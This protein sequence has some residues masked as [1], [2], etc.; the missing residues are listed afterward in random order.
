M[1]ELTT[2]SIPQWTYSHV[3]DRR[4]QTLLTRPRICHTYLTQRYLLTRNPQPYCEDC[5]V[6]LT[7]RHVL[8]ECSSLIA[9]RH[10]YLYHC[11][12]RDSGVYYIAQVLGPACLAPGHDVFKYLGKAGLL[13]IKTQVL[14]QGRKKRQ[15]HLLSRFID[16]KEGIQRLS[17]LAFSSAA[18]P[19]LLTRFQRTS[20][21]KISPCPA[22]RHRTYLRPCHTM[23]TS[24]TDC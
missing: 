19:Q 4:A 23:E 16:H 20:S 21:D 17:E 8:V 5:L 1:G 24:W 13:P 15:R 22:A 11:R 6:P 7:V 18:R 12:G 9:L 2:S 3:R 14:I 10:R